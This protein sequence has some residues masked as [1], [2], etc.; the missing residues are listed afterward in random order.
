[1][2]KQNIQNNNL[3]LLLIILSPII[4][5]YFPAMYIVSGV[6]VYSIV[7]GLAYVFLI[8][9]VLH[10]IRYY[11]HF[12]FFRFLVYF[13]LWVISSGIFLLILGKFHPI[14]FFTGVFI[15]LIYNNILW[16]LYPCAVF[17]MKFS[18]KTLIKI[19]T[20]AVYFICFWGVLNFILNH[21]FH[22][23]TS[24][25]QNILVSRHM[26]DQ[27]GS[28]YQ[29]ERLN[30]V[31]EEPGFMGGFICINLP[32]IFKMTETKFKIFKN[33]FFNMFIKHT[34]LPLV[35]ITIV[36]V[37]SPMW[38][39]IFF[40]TTFVYVSIQKFKYFKN[41]KTII[42][43]FIVSLIILASGIIFVQNSKIDISK[44]FLN[45]I[46]IVTNAL[47]SFE[48]LVHAEQSLGQRLISYHI[49]LK[50]FIKNPI[51]GT[52]YKNSER[53]ALPVLD[54]LNYNAVIPGII[55]VTNN[56]MSE[57]DR[58]MSLNG[59][60]LWILLSD[61]GLIG[62]IF[63][64]CFV[65]FSILKINQ[66]I[67]HIPPSIEKTFMESVKLSYVAILCFS[68]YDIRLNLPYLWFLFGLT[69]V[70]FKYYTN[71]FKYGG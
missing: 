20:I 5:L 30:A 64:F 62:T 23:D 12:K 60:I 69:P 45:R 42:K 46:K 19:C 17:P 2:L 1:M 27:F 29:G 34:F 28:R 9:I 25:I 26:L 31:F 48:T 68:I 32:I 3:F 71:N 56:A 67:S 41:L 38:I 18:L 8:P 65:I 15:Y 70:F 52:G 55:K 58:Y 63:F 7:I 13:C 36:L 39:I 50:L 6:P 59:A 40:I 57:N 44:T 49:R 53:N 66:I 51:T 4:F 35:F 43:T 16:Y 21:L 22:I 33:K 10:N 37:Q 14:S 11:F 61:T 47:S 24:C 54:T